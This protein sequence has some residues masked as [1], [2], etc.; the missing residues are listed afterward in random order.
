M[1][2]CYV[3]AL[4]DCCRENLSESMRGGGGNAGDQDMMIDA[5]SNI[6][7]LITFG[8]PPSDGTPAKSTI[9]LAYFRYL[10]SKANDYD[11]SLILPN[12]LLTWHGTDGKSETLPL[13]SQELRL[14]HSQWVAKAGSVPPQTLSFDVTAPQKSRG[15]MR[16]DA[17]ETLQSMFNEAA[18][19]HNV[20]FNLKLH[21]PLS[22]Q[23]LQS[24]GI[25]ERQ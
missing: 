11:G 12:A 22:A 15:D 7:L 10:K 21:K 18:P 2:G 19:K 17:M 3:V 14:V 6:N 5:E 16:M 13:I 4:L 8:C 25:T 1:D 23:E 20:L 24:K 9:A